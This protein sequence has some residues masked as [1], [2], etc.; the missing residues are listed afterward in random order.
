M[1]YAALLW[2]MWMRRRPA[3][4]ARLAQIEG[5]QLMQS[6]L[7][8]AVRPGAAL[9]LVPAVALALALAA[10]PARAQSASK[11]PPPPP[12]PGES[13]TLQDALAAA[14]ANNPTLQAARAQLRATDEGVPSALA[15]WRPMPASARRPRILIA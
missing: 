7:A 15:G 10:G 4:R 3:G 12:L 11:S 5:F 14:Y 2:Q 13:H 6:R 9:A 8:N 1:A